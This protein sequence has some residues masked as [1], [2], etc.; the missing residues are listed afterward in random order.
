MQRDSIPS[1]MQNEDDV[2]I[3]IHD[4]LKSF[5]EVLSFFKRVEAEFDV[6]KYCN[7]SNSGGRWIYQIYS[8]EFIEDLSGLLN[9]IINSSDITGPILEVMGGDGKLSEFLRFRLN[10]EIVTTDSKTSRDNIEFPKWVEKLEALEAITRYSPIVVL[11]SWESFYSGI[12]NEIVEMGIPTIWIGDPSR[13]AVGTGLEDK[14]HLTIQSD[15]LLGRSDKF[16]LKEHKTLIRL[17]NFKD[18]ED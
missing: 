14:D 9:R 16:S 18:L 13:S 15:Y 2:F 4:E 5:S 12:S 10:N 3:D 11:M 6:V 7:G 17:F 8:Q 1:W